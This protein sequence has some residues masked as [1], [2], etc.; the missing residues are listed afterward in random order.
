MITILLCVFFVT[1]ILVKYFV[2][3]NRMERYVKHLKIKGPVYP[4]IGNAHLMVGKSEAQLFKEVMELTIELGTPSKAYVGPLL[5]VGNK[6]RPNGQ[7]G[8]K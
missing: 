3:M 2:H 8:S 7:C 1:T 5:F 6:G 4:F